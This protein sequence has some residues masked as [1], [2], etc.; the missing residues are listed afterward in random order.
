MPV[1]ARARPR[2][3]ARHRPPRSQARQHLRHRDGVV[4][5]LDFG[6]AKLSRSAQA[7]RRA[8]SDGRARCTRR[9]GA[10]VGTLPYMSPEQW[11][12]DDDRSPHR[13]LGGRH[14]PV[15]DADRA[16]PARSAVAAAAARARPRTSTSRCRRSPRRCPSCPT[17]ARAARSIAASPSART[18]RYATAAELLAALEPLLPGRYGRRL[19]EDESPYPGPDRVPGGRRRSVLRARSRGH[20]TWSRGCATSRWSAWSAPSGVGKSS[21]V[22][23]GVIPALKSSGER[24]EVLVDPAGA[25]PAVQP[26]HAAAADRAGHRAAICGRR[27]DEH[28]ALLKRLRTEPGFLGTLLRSRARQKRRADPAVRRSVRGALHAASPTPSERR[29]F[30]A[31]LAG[32]ADDAATPLRVVVSMRSDFLD[33]A[34]ED[35]VFMERADAR[36]C[37]F[38]PPLDRDGMREAL[39]AAARDGR[40]P[41]RARRHGRRDA[42]RAR[43][44]ARARCRC[45]SSPPR[46]CGTRATARAA[47]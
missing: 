30:T 8:S 16:A 39:T 33:R 18:Q 25:Q 11:G 1:V 9:D 10:I 34:A 38:L 47:C 45:S 6:I 43:R 40:L 32:V 4:K 41:V 31:C 14:H 23:A 5:V 19:D 22:R 27:C 12:A 29:A 24:W 13:L 7:S 2:P 37:V 28:D 36:A 17:G 46:S 35:R 3:R 42:R 15:R 44:D 26:R 21:F 20:R